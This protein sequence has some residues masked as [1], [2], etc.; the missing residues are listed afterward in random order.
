ML[1]N[2]ATTMIRILRPAGKKETIRLKSAGEIDAM[3]HAG[4]IL[5]LT[6]RAMRDAIVPDVTTTLELDEIAGEMLKA[7]GATAPL[8]G[9]KPSFSEVAYLH[10]SCISINNEI[11]HGVPAANRICR[12]GDVVS[13]DM[14]AMVDGWCADSTITVP[15]GEISE[16]AKT[17]IKVT[18]ESLYKGIEAAKAGRFI[19]DV[20][21]A[22]QK[23]VEKAGYSVVREM[24]GHGIGQTPHE[25]G[26]DVPNY[27]KAGT[28]LRILTGMTFCIEP[29]VNR[30]KAEIEQRPWDPWT[31]F[32]AD[33]SLACHFEHTVAI[34]DKGAEILTALP[35]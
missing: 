35:K 1:P 29:M 9:Y 4:Q 17:L 8:N 11:I 16:E 5:A 34:T 10:N 30:G 28:G 13:L 6:L 15:V 23:H 2:F 14:D 18:R 26:I 21:N 32:T 12:T 25:E 7:H 27:G 20:G 24:V 31:I 19:G 3:R 33:G 22:V